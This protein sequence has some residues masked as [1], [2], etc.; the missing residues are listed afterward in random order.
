MFQLKVIKKVACSNFKY[1]HLVFIIL[2]FTSC[3]KEYSEK[4]EVESSGTSEHY[5]YI[6]FESESDF[7]EESPILYRFGS[8]NVL[9]GESHLYPESF[10]KRDELNKQILIEIQDTTGIIQFN[11]IDKEIFDSLKCTVYHRYFSKHDGYYKIK[12][13]F[14]SGEKI[15][16]EWVI[17]FEVTYGG[18]NDD[19]FRM[20]KDASY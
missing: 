4:W 7:Y 20:V 1:K 18:E 15:N 9:W 3:K 13:G 2:F 11:Y 19:K 5:D 16:G 12:K 6:K 17:D 10:F 14:V 8:F